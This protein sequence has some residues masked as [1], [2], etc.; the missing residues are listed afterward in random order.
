[1][2]DGIM[3]EAPDNCEEK[4]V[5][6]YEVMRENNL[7]EKDRVE[8]QEKEIESDYD[9]ARRT[10]RNLLTDGETALSRILELAKDGEH[11]NIIEVASGLIKNIAGVSKELLSLQKTKRELDKQKPE[12]KKNKKDEDKAGAVFIGSTTELNKLMDQSDGERS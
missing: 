7:S 8:R 11:P 12:P 9:M 5:V 1:M 6:A 3:D 2:V 10:L 4:N